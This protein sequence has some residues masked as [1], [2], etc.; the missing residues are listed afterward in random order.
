[1]RELMTA[2]NHRKVSSYIAD[3]QGIKVLVDDIEYQE[4]LFT[5]LAV[6]DP[7]VLLLI[8]NLPGAL[9]KRELCEEVL[10]LN[11]KMK[12]IYILC[13]TE[14]VAFIRFL[15]DKG[16]R[17]YFSTSDD[18]NELINA[19]LYEDPV[20]E[21]VKKIKEENKEEQK[22][23]ELEIKPKKIEIIPKDYKKV[24]GIA[25]VENAGKTSIGLLCAVLIGKYKKVALIDKSQTQGLRY[26]FASSH[27]AKEALENHNHLEIQKNVFLYTEVID[28]DF[29][30]FLDDIKQEYDAIIIDLGKDIEDS[31]VRYLDNLYIV[32]DSDISHTED[33]NGY[34]KQ[35]KEL[36]A[37]KKVRMIFNKIVNLGHI[38]TL[39][40]KLNYDKSIKNS[41]K[42]YSVKFL[43]NTKQ[44]DKMIDFDVSVLNGD[45]EFRSQVENI[46][47][48]MY[49]ISKSESNTTVK[50][51]NKHLGIIKRIGDGL[52]TA[53]CLFGLIPE[54]FIKNK[55][56]LVFI[57]GG[58]IVFILAKLNIIN[59]F[60]LGGITF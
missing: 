25:G 32:S 44:F 50:D 10:K 45:D 31:I 60:R 37:Y 14:D 52:Y 49:L 27:E 4:E 47:N 13:D 58:L 53:I 15:K 21:E 9:S 23:K 54:F 29:L 6:N 40:E 38:D 41:L 5:K 42:I 55:A 7:D 39:K 8:E 12:I 33:V 26:Y 22:D 19:I 17:D 1:M 36:K 11:K 20:V 57:I 3:K 34:F 43:V 24:I 30:M 59:L 18:V 51:T 2:I 48:D 28:E 16:I 35:I 46:A 56:I